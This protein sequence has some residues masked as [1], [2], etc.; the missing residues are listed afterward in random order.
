MIVDDDNDGVTDEND[1]FPLDSTET[2]DSDS[3]GI[4]NN[5]DTDD[6]GDGLLDGVEA[7][8]GT[9]PLLADTDGDG[10]SDL[11]EVNSNSDPLD[12]NST[13]KRLA[14]LVTESG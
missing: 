10:Y 3:D 12:A 13:T 5:A 11:D 9:N 8:N 14:Y 7:S 1:L 2:I 6:D 4:G